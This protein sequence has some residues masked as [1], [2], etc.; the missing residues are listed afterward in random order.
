MSIRVKNLAFAYEDFLSG[1]R[2]SLSRAAKVTAIVGPNGAG[3]DDFSEVPRGCPPDQPRDLFS[4]TAGTSPRSRAGK[5][6]GS[7][8]M[9]PRNTI[10]LQLPGPRISS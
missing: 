6:P 1:S 5:G 8:A 7:S 2:S 9:S 3:Q 4:S 10:R